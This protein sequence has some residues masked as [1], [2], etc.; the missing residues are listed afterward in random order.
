CKEQRDEAIQSTRH[1]ERSAA[2]QRPSQ[3]CLSQNLPPPRRGRAGVGVLYCLAAIKSRRSDQAQRSDNMTTKQS[4]SKWL[5]ER[6]V[7]YSEQCKNT[8]KA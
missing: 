3:Q 5:E 7:K 1:C 6:V 4:N 2:I 8:V